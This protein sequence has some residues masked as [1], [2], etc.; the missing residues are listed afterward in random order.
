[1]TRAGDRPARLRVL[2][3]PGRVLGPRSGSPRRGRGADRGVLRA[4]SVVPPWRGA[5]RRGARPRGCRTVRVLHLVTYPV[6]VPLHGG[7]AGVA[8]IAATYARAGVT[9]RV[10]AV[11]Q[12]EIYGGDRVGPHDIAF[13]VDSPQRRT[14][15]FLCTDLAS[16]DFAVEDAEAY[17]YFRRQF[18]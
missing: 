6:V 14:A 17:A 8:N 15:L 10:I 18:L 16:G 7:Q 3:R 13:P 2:V 5:A 12:P 9:S 4:E 11:Y 1:G